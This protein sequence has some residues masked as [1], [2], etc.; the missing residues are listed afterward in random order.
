MNKVYFKQV[1]ENLYLIKYRNHFGDII[2]NYVTE[3][4]LEEFGLKSEL[5]EM[6]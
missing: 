6:E 3:M 2:E 4:V 5:I 1:E